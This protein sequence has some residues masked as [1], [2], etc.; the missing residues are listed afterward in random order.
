MRF[1][2]NDAVLPITGIK[3]CKDDKNKPC[4]LVSFIQER[5]GEV[6]FDCF[7][8]YT[9]PNQDNIINGMGVPFKNECAF[10]YLLLTPSLI[11]Q[12]PVTTN[13]HGQ[14]YRSPLQVWSF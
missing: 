13:C 3:G 8:N 6:D 4:D 12:H 14:S 1:I 7:A 2:L 11:V 9:F 5:I 10:V